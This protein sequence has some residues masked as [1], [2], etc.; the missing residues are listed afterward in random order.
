MNSDMLIIALIGIPFLSIICMAVKF[1]PVYLKARKYGV[2]TVGTVVGYKRYYSGQLII[3]PI[4]M[5]NIDGEEVIVNSHCL[6]AFPFYKIGEK[7][8]VSFLSDG[9]RDYHFVKI[10]SQD[11]ET[12]RWGDQQMQIDTHSNVA[13]NDVKHYLDTIVEMIFVIFM[14]MAYVVK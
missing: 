13:I 9:V 7:V 2:R 8:N 11:P 14:F 1:R 10:F 12:G 4:I 5:V 6:L 3:F